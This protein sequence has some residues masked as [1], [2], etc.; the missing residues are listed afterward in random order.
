M[1][2]QF[3]CVNVNVVLTSNFPNYFRY[4]TGHNGKVEHGIRNEAL[5]ET[6][7]CY[8]SQE[9]LN[10]NQ[11]DSKYNSYRYKSLLEKKLAKLYL[12]DT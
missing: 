11:I 3:V 2:Q 10:S 4:Q 9:Y 7:L 1:G 8:H 12:W 5:G 6:E